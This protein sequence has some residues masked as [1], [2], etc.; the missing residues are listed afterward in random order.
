M[1]DSSPSVVVDIFLQGK[2]NVT[3]LVTVQLQRAKGWAWA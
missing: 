2:K 1:L 3:A